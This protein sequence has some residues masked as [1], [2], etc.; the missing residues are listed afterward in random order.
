MTKTDI[1][2]ELLREIQA[3][4]IDDYLALCCGTPL[5]ATPGCYAGT[6]KERR[7]VPVPED[8][9]KDAEKMCDDISHLHYIEQEL[10]RTKEASRCTDDS[11]DLDW[12]FETDEFNAE[13]GFGDT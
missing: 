7:R 12:L 8:M 2:V 3:E 11:A 9:L 4:A 13:N 6:E 5:G 1:P 10:Y